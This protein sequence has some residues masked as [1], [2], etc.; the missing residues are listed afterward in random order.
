MQDT[1]T[2]FEKN[3]LDTMNKSESSGS[4]LDLSNFRVWKRVSRFFTPIYLT[5]YHL[6]SIFSP[7]HHLIPLS[8]NP[9]II[10]PRFWGVIEGFKKTG[11]KY[12]GLNES[13]WKEVEPIKKLQKILQT[14][15]NLNKNWHNF[16]C[17]WPINHA[18]KELF[19]FR[20]I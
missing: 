14:Y 1:Y 11:L 13:G 5:P 6:T 2:K 9:S 12:A 19:C 20:K 7:L 17:T 10:S 18:H 16:I 8:L 15:T 4:Y 3:D